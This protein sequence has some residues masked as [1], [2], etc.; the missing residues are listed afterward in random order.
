[1]TKTNEQTATKTVRTKKVLGVEDIKI[2]GKPGK[3]PKAERADLNRELNKLSAETG[4]PRAA[5]AEAKAK[6][7]LARGINGRDA[8]QSS[9]AIADQS[10]GQPKTTNKADSVTQ[11]RTQKPAKTDKSADK[12]AKLEASDARKITFVAENPKRPG[13]ASFDRFAKYKKGMTVAQA[14]AAGITRADIDWD[15]KR[16]FIKFG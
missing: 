6:A 9:K 1:M 15:S 11:K 5:M 4:A 14:L 13:T 2:N 7:Q 8:P 10:R 3:S 12:A 16:D